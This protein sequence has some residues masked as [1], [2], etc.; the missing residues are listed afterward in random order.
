MTATGTQT[1]IA[2]LAPIESK[3]E[4]PPLDWVLV[5]SGEVL[6]VNV[7]LIVDVGLPLGDE[8]V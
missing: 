7:E 6:L 5:T 4:L 2:T 3:E 8:H 1:P